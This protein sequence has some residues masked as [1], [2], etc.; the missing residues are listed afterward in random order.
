MGLLD[1]KVAV[2]TGAGGGLG[3]AHALAFAEEGAKIVVN[4]LG[5][6]RDGDGSDDSAASK[7][8]KE[9]KDLG[10]EAVPNFDSVSTM[11]GGKNIVQTALDNFGQ[12]DILV[13]NAGILRDKSM[14]K[15]PED[16][17]D[18]VVDVHLKGTFACSQPAFAAMKEAGNGGR[19]I[20]T[21]SL[22]G[23]L[24][25]FGQ[26]N[27][28]SAKAGIAGFTRVVAIEGKKSGITCNAIAPVA[29][30]RLTE[31]LPMFAGATDDAI[32]PQ[33]VSPIVVF[34]A[35]AMASEI[36]GKIIGTQANKL[37]EY[38]MMTTEGVVLDHMWT[39]EEIKERWA[40]IT[41]L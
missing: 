4:D 31:D 23:L 15:M 35:S 21:S 5:G 34:L 14:S 1:G 2:I 19:I 29:I 40:E 28:A 12:I 17:W 9:I 33:L 30:T 8:V 36:T 13:N 25:N 38:K 10:G 26:A 39:P 20:N 18:I 22:A 41:K 37:F 6:T 27:Y 32:G 24:G 7:V 16:L 3:R 11:A